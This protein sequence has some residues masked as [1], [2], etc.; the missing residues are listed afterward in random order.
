ME[1]SA[2]K[3][4]FASSEEPYKWVLWPVNKKGTWVERYDELIPNGKQKILETVNSLDLS[5]K[6][7]Q[8]VKKGLQE[9]KEI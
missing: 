6:E 1:Q 4:Q 3:L 5:R 7:K 8:A 2:V 9:A